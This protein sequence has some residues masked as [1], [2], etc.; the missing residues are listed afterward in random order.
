MSL[1]ISCKIEVLNCFVLKVFYLW[2]D[3]NYKKCNT[4]N[5]WFKYHENFFSFFSLS[6]FSPSLSCKRREKEKAAAAVGVNGIFARN[7]WKAVSIPSTR[8]FFSSIHSETAVKR[9]VC[10]KKKAFCAVIGSVYSG[11]W[12]RQGS[13]HGCRL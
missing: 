5:F 12:W 3:P 11:L 6:V 8:F 13:L 2:Y 7:I 4:M 1:C 9:R 10:Y